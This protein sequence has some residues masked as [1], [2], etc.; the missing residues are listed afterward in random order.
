MIEPILRQTHGQK[1]VKS[2]DSH[3]QLFSQPLT[4]IEKLGFQGQLAARMDII[5]ILYIQQALSSSMKTLE[6]DDFGKDL[7]CQTIKDIFAISTKS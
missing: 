1:A 3:R 6:N 2:W 4:Q 5:S 7:I